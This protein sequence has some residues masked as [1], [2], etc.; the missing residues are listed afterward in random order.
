MPTRNHRR[1][2]YTTNISDERLDATRR[3]SRLSQARSHNCC[4]DNSSIIRFR[5]ST[6]RLY[7]SH[8][9]RTSSLPKESI[10]PRTNS[11]HLDI[12]YILVPIEHRASN[13]S[14]MTYT[15]CVVRPTTMT[16]DTTYGIAQAAS[17]TLLGKYNI[18]IIA[19]SDTDAPKLEY[20]ASGTTPRPIHGEG[21]WRTDLDFTSCGANVA[22]IFYRPGRASAWRFSLSSL[23]S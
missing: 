5:R 9:L 8:E 2:T 11:H 14:R 13:V 21:L 10:S 12:D 22:S 4:Q 3:A 18:D 1:L 20:E 17:S 16:R 19:P 23:L 7:G 6:T 15:N